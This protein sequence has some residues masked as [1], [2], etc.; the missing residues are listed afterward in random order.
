MD[1]SIKTSEFVYLPPFCF[2]IVMHLRV[3]SENERKSLKIG[4]IHNLESFLYA[5]CQ[6]RKIESL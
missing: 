6:I 1:K 4:L 2:E 3:F 5:T